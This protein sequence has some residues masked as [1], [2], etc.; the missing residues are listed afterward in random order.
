MESKCKFFFPANLNR[1]RNACNFQINLLCFFHPLKF[2]L[3]KTMYLPNVFHLC[4]FKLSRTSNAFFS[5][6]ASPTGTPQKHSAMSTKS[7]NK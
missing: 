7:A 6:P 5:T 3:P 4:H 1:K 2:P